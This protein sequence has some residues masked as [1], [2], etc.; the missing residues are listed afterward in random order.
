MEMDN[1]KELDQIIEL[2][3]GIRGVQIKHEDLLNSIKKDI[4]SILKEK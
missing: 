1:Q 4:E 2:L 3:V